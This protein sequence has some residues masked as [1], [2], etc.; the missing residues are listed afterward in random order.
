LLSHA[1]D[2]DK[3]LNYFGKRKIGKPSFAS[4][5]N[6]H[7]SMLFHDYMYETESLKRK[8]VMPLIQPKRRKFSFCYT[9]AKAASEK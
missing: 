4:N 6:K 5:L 1:E 3:I 9:K 7:T 2:I 8:F